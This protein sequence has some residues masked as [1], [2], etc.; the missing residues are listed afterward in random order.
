[1]RLINVLLAGTLMLAPVAVLAG[2][3]EDDFSQGVKAASSGDY[4]AAL[5]HFLQAQA[6]GMNKPGL[7]YNLAVAYY[8]LGQYAEARKVF[9]RLAKDPK[10]TDIAYFNLGL[11]AN[12]TGDERAAIDWFLRTYHNSDNARLKALSA[13]ALDRLGVDVK[14]GSAKKKWGGFAAANLGYDS[15]VR[16]ANE[17]LIGVT[18]ESDNSME[19]LA[20][21]NYWLTGGRE[22]GL[23]I[24]ATADVQKYQNLSDYDFSLFQLGLGHFSTLGKW[25]LRLTGSWNESYLGGN[26]Y[27][28]LF[29]AE[30][31]GRYGMGN[32]KYLRLRYR[33]NYIS[34]TSSDTRL[35]ALDGL[36]HQLRAGLQVNK[37]VHRYQAYYQLD[38]NDRSDRLVGTDFTSYSPTRHAVR[39]I[40]RLSMGAKWKGRL[41]ARYRYSGYNDPN[42]VGGVETVTRVDKQ[43]RLGARLARNF[44]KYWEV[45]G[46]YNY[47]DNNSNIAVD[48]YKRHVYYLGVNRFF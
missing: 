20:A 5:T 42:R 44:A 14:K 7:D 37:G 33:F 48:S 4:K 39:A 46:S 26:S 18:N 9:T 25:N 27:Q 2:T 6:Q 34:S 24:S 40:A 13:R 32:N 38:L 45:E 16:L 28:R 41:D 29:G 30:A 1:M 15:N 17:D 12:K 11:I 10:F 35:E 3:A 19:V 23:R 43:L 21:G 8:R 36:R 47:Y 22:G 31:R